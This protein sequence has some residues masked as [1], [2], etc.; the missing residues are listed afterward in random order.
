MMRDF[1]YCNVDDRHPSLLVEDGETVRISAKGERATP[2]LSLVKI[3]PRT[4]AAL[5]VLAG[6]PPET[7][8]R[9]SDASAFEPIEETERFVDLAEQDED[10]KIAGYS[11][12]FLS[13]ILD[14]FDPNE[15]VPPA[16]VRRLVPR[17]QT[18]HDCNCPQ[19]THAEPSV[20]S[21]ARATGVHVVSATDASLFAQEKRPTHSLRFSPVPDFLRRFEVFAR[22]LRFHD[23]VVGRNATLILDSDVSF[24]V[25]NNFLC[26]QGSR[27]VQKG[28][29]LTVD[30]TSL[31]R[32]SL[33]EPVWS[34]VKN[35]LIVDWE[36]LALQ[37]HT[38][39]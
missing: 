13:G 20:D 28:K 27:I 26:Y 34:V 5:L 9:L 31:M 16:S 32:G 39:P 17:R 6:R 35:A 24:T 3:R 18:S 36:K 1:L 25:A 22:L 33:L 21:L 19:R 38:K 8:P 23:I 29:Y 10:G 7:A 11:V 30:V 15:K 12:P 37:P 4:T 2:G 14:G